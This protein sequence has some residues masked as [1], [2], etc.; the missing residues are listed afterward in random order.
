MENHRTLRYR[1]RLQKLPLRNE[2]RPRI[3]GARKNEEDGH[4]LIGAK[5]LRDASAPTSAARELSHK[6]YSQRLHSLRELGED[7]T[8]WAAVAF[9]VAVLAVAVA[10]VERSKMALRDSPGCRRFSFRLDTT[11]TP[12]FALA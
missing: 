8:S 6:M 10:V 12:A 4:W 9:W 11:A 7:F 1:D 2:G 5:K 3:R